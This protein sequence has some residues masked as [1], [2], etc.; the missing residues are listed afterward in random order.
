MR[1]KRGLLYLDVVRAVLSRKL[2][3]LPAIHDPPPRD[4][5]FTCNLRRP[6]LNLSL[7]F[8]S[9]SQVLD[10]CHFSCR[11][12]VFR[13]N[14]WIAELG[15]CLAMG[16]E[17]SKCAGLAI[18]RTGS[19]PNLSGLGSSKPGINSISLS[20]FRLSSQLSFF[21]ERHRADRNR[22][23]ILSSAVCRHYP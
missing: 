14:V 16:P 11:M 7:R 5:A 6:R 3:T 21:I 4:R 18:V 10:Y 1:A 2:V 15:A 12:L 19:V 23:S 9:C 22:I 20:L 8:V 17:R 13:G